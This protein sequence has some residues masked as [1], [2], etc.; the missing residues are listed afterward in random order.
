[1]VK[2]FKKVKPF[3][4]KFV[5]KINNS[6]SLTKSQKRNIL[7]KKTKLSFKYK[8]KRNRLN[9]FKKFIKL[10]PQNIKM[11]SK[12]F[13]HIH[14]KH[15]LYSKK[16][17]KL[18]NKKWLSKQAS[19]L[20]LV[21]SY[22]LKKLS[23]YNNNNRTSSLFFFKNLAYSKK[24]LLNNISRYVEKFHIIYKLKK[25]PLVT[26][27]KKKKLKHANNILLRSLKK[28][29]LYK[30][31]IWWKKKLSYRKTKFR[32]KKFKNYKKFKLLKTFW[33]LTDKSKINFR[34]NHFKLMLVLRKIFSNYYG[35]IKKRR[36]YNLWKKSKKKNKFIIKLFNSSFSRLLEQKLDIV[37]VHMN[38]LPSVKFAK[39][40]INHRHIY[41][42]K[43][44]ITKQHYFVKN[45]EIVQI[46]PWK[47]KVL[48]KSSKY[49]YKNLYNFWNSWL[50]RR[51]SWKP[52]S[53]FELSSQLGVG[54][55]V[56]NPKKFQLFKTKYRTYA[57]SLKK[58]NNKNFL[59]YF[60][61]RLF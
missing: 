51:F 60:N 47:L 45:Q 58:R 38:F 37:L 9:F 14:K 59:Y 54:M 1:M 46:H 18:N 57:F 16:S 7:K 19:I 6:F 27:Y 55:F 43:K 39:Q 33:F 26:V 29:R 15:F 30:H 34:R 20:V 50:Y 61:D 36:L 23:E 8:K 3:S 25:K 2:Y 56:E 21:N 31:S 49:F 22:K 10:Y 44:L 52:R 17:T 4:K 40:L 28:K 13:H 42:N 35:N 5:H 53:Y 32:Y 24:L 11:F 48:L 12:L 41:V